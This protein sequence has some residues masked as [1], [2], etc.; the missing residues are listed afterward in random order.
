MSLLEVKAVQSSVKG[1]FRQLPKAW[2]AV[3][4]SQE[5]VNASSCG[6]HE[7]WR[8]PIAHVGKDPIVG[9][10]GDRVN[11]WDPVGTRLGPG[12]DPVGTRLDFFLRTGPVA[13]LS[14][15]LGSNAGRHR[16]VWLR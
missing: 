11:G 10:S 2:Q 6:S 16:A 12:W 1:A 8:C 13:R 14:A 15:K 7:V 9:T 3:K 4:G 5:A